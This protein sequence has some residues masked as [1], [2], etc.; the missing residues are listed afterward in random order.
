MLGTISYANVDHDNLCYP[1]VGMGVEPFVNPWHI[2]LQEKTHIC[3]SEKGG[4]L[5]MLGPAGWHV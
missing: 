1:P 4:V 2:V 3:F 5:S